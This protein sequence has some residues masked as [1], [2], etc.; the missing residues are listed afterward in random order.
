M[1]EDCDM[2]Y[3]AMEQVIK[4]A[5]NREVWSFLNAYNETYFREQIQTWQALAKR[6]VTREREHKEKLRLLGLPTDRFSY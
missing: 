1:N 4:C 3:D 5:S 6:C 2:N